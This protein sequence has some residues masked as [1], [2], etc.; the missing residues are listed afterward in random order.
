LTEQARP[1]IEPPARNSVKND[2]VV[3]E[4]EHLS[5]VFTDRFFNAVGHTKGPSAIPEHL[6][7]DAEAAMLP[8]I[9]EGG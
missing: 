5:S 9:I 4:S 7:F 3:L 6:A 2:A 1:V 8:I